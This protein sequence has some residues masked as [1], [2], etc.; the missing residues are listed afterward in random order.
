MKNTLKTVALVLA[1]ALVFVGGYVLGS[2]KKDTGS[3]LSADF[4]KRYNE[5]SEYLKKYYYEGTNQQ[6]FE[7][8]MLH[9]LASSLGDPYTRYLNEE[10][11]AEANAQDAESY[12]GIGVVISVDDNKMPKVARIYKN[13]PAQKAGL[14]ENDVFTAIDGVAV[15][16]NTELSKISGKLR[17]TSGTE[18]EVTVDR[19]GK[20]LTMKIVR[21]AVAI[22]YVSTRMLS[23]NIGYLSLSEFS[24]HSYSEVQAGVEALQAQGMKKLVIDLRSNPGGYVDSAVK[25]ADIFLDQG[26][27]T[28]TVDVQGNRHDY[29]SDKEKLSIPLVILVNGYSASASEIVVGALHDRGVATIVGTKT[30]GKGIIQMPFPLSTG[31]QLNVTIARYFTPNGVC[32]HGIGITPDHVVELPADV[33]NG[34]VKL[35]DKTDSQLQKAV[36]LLKG[37]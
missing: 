16:P 23:G 7:N 19:S 13:S 36:E 5:I 21:A 34:T 28:Y 17:G 18:V 14:L 6:E 12:V 26:I 35:T 15:E 2:Y 31:G 8:G 22:E 33:L 10:E 27:V 1:L 25:I 30:Y 4:L 11:L 20:S 32:I 24:Q 37:M 29:S 3:A 9:G